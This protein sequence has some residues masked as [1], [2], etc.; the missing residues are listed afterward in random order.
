MTD[1]SD[2]FAEFEREIEATFGPILRDHHFVVTEQ[3]ITLES[4]GNAYIGYASE[5]MRIRFVRDRGYLS[6]DVAPA[7]H[8]VPK[9]YYFDLRSLLN[10][11]VPNSVKQDSLEAVASALAQHYARIENFVEPHDYERRLENVRAFYRA[12]FAPGEI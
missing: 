4:F 2:L 6:A 12:K 10:Y 7:L 5:T 3:Y 11:L 8:S 9:S 1:S